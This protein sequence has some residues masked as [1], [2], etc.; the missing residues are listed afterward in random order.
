MKEEMAETGASVAELE[1]TPEWDWLETASFLFL[2]WLG[3][4][5]DSTPNEPEES[6]GV[7]QTAQG[8]PMERWMISGESVAAVYYLAEAEAWVGVAYSFPAEDEE[9]K[10]LADYSFSTFRVD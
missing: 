9:L 10:A 4:Y 7:S 5:P 8:I 3:P 1:A 2:F 6:L